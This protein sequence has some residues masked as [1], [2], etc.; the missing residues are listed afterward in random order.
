MPNPPA[1]GTGLALGR[2]GRPDAR[3]PDPPRV[4]LQASSLAIFGDTGDAVLDE[5]SPPSGIGPRE[6]VTVCLAWEHAFDLATRD[7]GR[8]VLLRM[9]IAIGGRDDPATTQLA[10]LT[11]LGL[12]GTIGTGRQWV[13]WVGLD[14]L[15]RV[16]LAALDDE[17][18]A[19]TYHAASPNPV[20]NAEMMATYR[21]LLAAPFG[22]PS[23]D[24]L[25]RLGA[26]LLGSSASLAL[27]GR[28]AAPKRLLE[29]GFGFQQ[30]TFEPALRSALSQTGPLGGPG[31]LRRP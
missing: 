11:R 24:L 19:G 26:P 9:G 17:S 13:S 22:L 16:M 4:W 20:T 12:G 25:V 29:H 30:P 5:S 14:D 10:R 21:R 18:M 2:V 15:V 23:P 28:R 8:K 1:G 27:T 3:L 6:M 31:L 7:V